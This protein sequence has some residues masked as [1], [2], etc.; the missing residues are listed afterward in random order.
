MYQKI[1]AKEY[2]PEPTSS[3]VLTEAQVDSLL[4][5]ETNKSKTGL[6]MKYSEE[7]FAT[8]RF[9]ST[10][11]TGY[12]ANKAASENAPTLINILK[13]CKLL[14]GIR[15]KLLQIFLLIMERDVSVECCVETLRERD[16]E[17][18]SYIEVERVG[19]NLLSCVDSG[20]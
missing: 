4:E 13:R 17:V 12:L 7:I 9:L 15:K 19:E 6:A 14:Y 10:E 1:L 16:S 8:V 20:V 5:F 3:K 2:T 11:I 18:P